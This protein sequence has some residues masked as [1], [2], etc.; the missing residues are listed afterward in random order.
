MIC[1]FKQRKT[2]LQPISNL[3]QCFMIFLIVLISAYGVFLTIDVFEGGTVMRNE[4]INE[5]PIPVPGM[6]IILR[7]EKME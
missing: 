5:I 7:Y 2:E 3:R 1:D 6:Y 4:I